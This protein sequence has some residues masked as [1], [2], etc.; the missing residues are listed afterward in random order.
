MSDSIRTSLAAAQQIADAICLLSA[1]ANSVPKGD[2][3]LGHLHR[4]A[5]SF[6]TT[7][8]SDGFGFRWPEYRSPQSVHSTPTYGLRFRL[9][10]LFFD[11]SG[12]PDLS[13]AQRAVWVAA[14]RI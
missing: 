9:G 10:S 1:P 6:R 3:E 4:R 11:P 2:A 8:A 14:R 7:A 13:K 5:V 12:C